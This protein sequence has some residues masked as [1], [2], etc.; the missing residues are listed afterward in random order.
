MYDIMQTEG[1]FVE[2]GAADG[3]TGSKTLYMERT[4]KWKR[5]LIEANRK[6]FTEVLS[7]K[8]NAYSQYPSAL[9]WSPILYTEVTW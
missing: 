5:V 9:A 7:R 8:R 2:C 6:Y 4:L 1:F 3:E